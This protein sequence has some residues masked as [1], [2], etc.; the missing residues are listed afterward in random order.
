MFNNSS[1]DGPTLQT[2]TLCINVMELPI[3]AFEM[4]EGFGIIFLYITETTETK[5]YKNLVAN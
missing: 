2:L 3:K 5:I 4:Y 1:Q